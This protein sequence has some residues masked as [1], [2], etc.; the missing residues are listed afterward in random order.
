MEC[1][2]IISLNVRAAPKFEAAIDNWLAVRDQHRMQPSDN[3]EYVYN[4]IYFDLGAA[5]A[6]RY[7]EA[8]DTREEFE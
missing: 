5:F 7:S 4:A 3:S 1:N 2:K 8:P 6:E